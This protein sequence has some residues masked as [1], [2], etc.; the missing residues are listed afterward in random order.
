M[1]RIL[2]AFIFVAFPLA[3]ALAVA[4]SGLAQTNPG[5]QAPVTEA[6]AVALA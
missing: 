3:S 4:T 5:R 1:R 6:P 2:T